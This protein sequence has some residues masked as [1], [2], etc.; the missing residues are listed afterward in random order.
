MSR[1][2]QG[3]AGYSCRRPARRMHTAAIGH[4]QGGVCRVRPGTIVVTINYRLGALAERGSP[5][6]L[7]EAPWPH[8]SRIS[9]AFQKREPADLS[10]VPLRPNVETDFAAE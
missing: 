9:A 7:T 3:A 10:L 2:S 8:F 5:S 6:S 1:R 4:A